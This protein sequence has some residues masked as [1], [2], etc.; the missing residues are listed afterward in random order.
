MCNPDN[1]GSEIKDLS[2][3]DRDLCNPKFKFS[4]EKGCP[5]FKAT[6]IIAFIE[7]NPWIIGTILIAFGIV[8]AF[9]GGRLFPKVLMAAF[10]GTVFAVV[11]LVLSAIG[12]MK[13][14]E[15]E[16]TG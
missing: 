15:G 11:I 12:M 5:V 4:N 10:G 13:A 8:S 7:K 16:T 1:K 14:L 2:V 9:F 3:D 6:G